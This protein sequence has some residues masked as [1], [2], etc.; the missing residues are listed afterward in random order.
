MC[1][2]LV[3]LGARGGLARKPP[4]QWKE[5]APYILDYSLLTASVEQNKKR[6]KCKKET[7]LSHP[8]SFERKKKKPYALLFAGFIFILSCL[9]SAASVQ[10]DL[11]DIILQVWTVCPPGAV[12]RGGWGGGKKA[13]GWRHL[14]KSLPG[15]STSYNWNTE[16]LLVSCVQGT[17]CFPLIGFT[18]W[19]WLDRSIT[20]ALS[21]PC[22]C[23][24]TLQHKRGFIHINKS[25]EHQTHNKVINTL[26]IF[27]WS[28]WP[29]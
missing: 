9:T 8:T 16:N 18:K 19:C 3:A 6:G 24:Q 29:H 11:H 17:F 22:I 20:V 7:L 10:V 27:Y 23:E 14:G 1:P 13:G 2:P 28:F 5:H 15:L 4:D 12:L 26:H 21:N 25:T